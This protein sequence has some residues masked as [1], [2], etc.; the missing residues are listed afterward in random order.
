MEVV[1]ATAQ[2]VAACLHPEHDLARRLGDRR[3]PPRTVAAVDEVRAPEG[4]LAIVARLQV[5]DHSPH[6]SPSARSRIDTSLSWNGLSGLTGATNRQPLRGA[7]STCSGCSCGP[8]PSPASISA[9]RSTSSMWVAVVPLNRIGSRGWAAV[10]SRPASSLQVGGERGAVRGAP[11]DAAEA[12]TAGVTVTPPGSP[13]QAANARTSTTHTVGRA[14]EDRVIT[15]NPFFWLPRYSATQ[16]DL[17]PRER[18]VA[19]PSV[20]ADRPWRLSDRHPRE[21]RASR[22]VP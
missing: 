12:A 3:R 22:P 1:V 5:S 17:P 10:N 16:R 13:L 11:S 4:T 9:T 19:T 8:L 21:V 18:A 14:T 15:G 6:C 2:V 20:S 7:L